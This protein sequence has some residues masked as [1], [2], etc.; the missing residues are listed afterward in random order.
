MTLQRLGEQGNVPE[1]QER[2]FQK[3]SYW[4]YTTREGV[5]I[6][7]FDN[8][9]EARTGATDF[10]EFIQGAGS[11]MIPTLERYGQDAA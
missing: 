9:S 4:Y 6:G 10:I 11:E 1:R 2:F 8:L 3:D 7:P 5:A